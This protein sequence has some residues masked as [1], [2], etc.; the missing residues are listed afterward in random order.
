MI[1]FVPPSLG[2]AFLKSKVL[3]YEEKLAK[4]IETIDAFSIVR[5]RS[6]KASD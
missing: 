1:K 3:Q 2:K 6:V 5:S 4:V